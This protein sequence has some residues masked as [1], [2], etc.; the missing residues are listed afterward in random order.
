MGGRLKGGLHLKAA[1]GT[2]MA[3]AMLTLLHKLGCDDM[4]TFGDSTSEFDLNA[5]AASAT[6]A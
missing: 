5:T 6:V 2:P 4:Q 1:D 3:N